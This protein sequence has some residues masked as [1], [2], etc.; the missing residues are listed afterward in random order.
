MALC[1]DCR[2]PTRQGRALCKVCHVKHNPCT[3]CDRHHRARLCCN[4]LLSP[5]CSRCRKSLGAPCLVES[6]I[7]PIDLRRACLG[8]QLVRPC[9][10]FATVYS[11]NCRECAKVQRNAG[12]RV[13]IQTASESVGIGTPWATCARCKKSAH[14]LSPMWRGAMHGLCLNCTSTCTRTCRVC[15]VV[16]LKSEMSWL[17]NVC[18]PCRR[19]SQR[20]RVRVSM[21]HVDLLLSISCVDQGPGFGIGVECCSGPQ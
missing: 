13:Q 7:H 10:D 14:V 1:G 4:T 19:A 20:R 18:K 3:I 8:C 6:C 9:R 2:R 5:L 16:C 12:R 17:V 15:M 21:A 11:V